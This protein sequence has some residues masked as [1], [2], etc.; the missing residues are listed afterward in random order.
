MITGFVYSIAALAG[1]LAGP[2]YDIGPRLGASPPAYLQLAQSGSGR[3]PAPSIY[4]RPDTGAPAPGDSSPPAEKESNLQPNGE[5]EERPYGQF[6]WVEARIG[7]WNTSFKASVKSTQGT[8][9]GTDINL[10]DQLGFARDQGVV[11]GELSLRLSG[12]V[13]IW[14][15]RFNINYQSTSRLTEELVFKGQ[16]YKVNTVVDSALLVACT[17]LGV[18]FDLV[19]GEY[20]SFG[21]GFAGNYI[22]NSTQLTA[23]NLI[24]SAAD[25]KIM[26]P[27]ITVSARLYPVQMLGLGLDAS[28]V[29]FSG[30]YLYDISA[31][32]EVNLIRFVGISMGW[33]GIALDVNSGGDNV[34]LGW[35]GLFAR[36]SARF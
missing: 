27:M 30:S 17:R 32:A 19:S 6:D 22:D 36:L 7:F 26:V 31:F 1:A 4:D 15:D 18:N 8:L 16:V 34:S 21:L 23:Y 9:G 20:G 5:E 3:Q 35:S 13:R 33:K 28:W 2:A 29:G 11:Q 10:S 24:T 14:V 12:V 25:V